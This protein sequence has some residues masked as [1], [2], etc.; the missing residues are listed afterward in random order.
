[1]HYV[2]PWK[3]KI[4]LLKTT[5]LH[6]NLLNDMV[7]PLLPLQILE[8]QVGQYLAEW[9]QE[10]GTKL[11]S[12][13]QYSDAEGKVDNVI[14]WLREWISSYKLDSREGWK[15][16]LPKVKVSRLRRMSWW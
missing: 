9:A 15:S 7:M 16:F 14:T 5:F 3:L 11:R 8:Y 6:E 13:Y 2:P 4:E 10:L 12:T 1:M